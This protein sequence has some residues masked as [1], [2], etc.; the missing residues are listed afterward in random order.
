LENNVWDPKLGNAESS[1]AR[2]KEIE[3]ARSK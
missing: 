1:K 3:E 2:Q